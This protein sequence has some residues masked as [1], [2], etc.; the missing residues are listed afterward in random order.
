M[1]QGQHVLFLILP[2]RKICFAMKKKGQYF[3]AVHRSYLFA[4]ISFLKVKSE[5]ELRCL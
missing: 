4:L 1:A 2:T 5:L 3:V